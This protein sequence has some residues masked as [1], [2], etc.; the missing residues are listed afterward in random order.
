MTTTY[1]QGRFVIL[2]I[3]SS[4]KIRIRILQSK[5]NLR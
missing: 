4:R 5:P 3:V 2:L 1:A